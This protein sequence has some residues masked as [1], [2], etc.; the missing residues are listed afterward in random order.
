SGITAAER[1]LTLDPSLAEAHAAKGRVLASTGRVDDGLAE[2]EQAFRLDPDSYDV[3]IAL[4]VTSHQL[5]RDEAAIEHY[6]RAAQLLPSDYY[7]LSVATL[8]YVALKR[9]DDANAAWRRAL[10]R[11]EREI[12]LRPDNASALVHGAIGLACLGEKERAKQWA[13]RAQTLEPDEPMELYNL[14]CALAQMSEIERAVDLLE[15]CTPKLRPD[16][17][18]W[19]KR[20]TDLIPLHEHPGYKALIARAEKRLATA[21]AEQ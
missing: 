20:D 11:I 14:A 13:A 5:G 9:R 10:D 2:L 15:S 18:N 12:A 21:Q 8:S 4:A 19:I 3:R 17:V 1:A 16:M 6:E 7:C